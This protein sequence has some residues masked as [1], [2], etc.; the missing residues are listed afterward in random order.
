MTE[1]G[2]G[3]WG[4]E[5]MNAGPPLLCVQQ[6]PLQTLS[7]APASSTAHTN[8]RAKVTQPGL[9]GAACPGPR[10]SGSHTTRKDH[11]H[12]GIVVSILAEV[13]PQLPSP[14]S[15]EPS[16]TPAFTKRFPSCGEMGVC[17]PATAKINHSTVPPRNP[18]DGTCEPCTQLREC[19][20]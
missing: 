9:S 15:G 10:S 5:R 19:V 12:E 8:N 16:V 17:V 11:M 20:S 13:Q 1:K 6:N 4:L 3:K 14:Q 2:S 18:G 7:T